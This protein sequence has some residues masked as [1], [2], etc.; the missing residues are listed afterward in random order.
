MRLLLLTGMALLGFCAPADAAF[1]SWTLTNGGSGNP[2]TF[3]ANGSEAGVTFSTSVTLS[4]I[5]GANIRSNVTG[6]GVDGGGGSSSINS[7]QVVSVN[8][9][10]IDSVANGTVTFSGFTGVNL[11]GFDA[12]DSG[13]VAGNLVNG[14]GLVALGGSPAPFLMVGLTDDLVSP[15]F[16]AN[17]LFGEFT[18]TPTAVPE[19]S[20]LAA[21]AIFGIGGVVGRRRRRAKQALA[22]EAKPANA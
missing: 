3:T 11:I 22:A 20:S 14:N 2:T 7:S 10:V 15:G 12:G 18:V 4:T 16:Q 13:V 1:V 8:A 21:L 6:A 9:P 5:L 17:G 19:P